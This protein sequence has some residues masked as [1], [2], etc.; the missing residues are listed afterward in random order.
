M[1]LECIGVF[2]GCCCKEVYRYPNNQSWYSINMDE[3]DSPL[4]Q[5]STNGGISC[6][7]RY[8]Y[9]QYQAF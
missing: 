9:M 1:W 4:T 5:Y 8:M 7:I 3:R 6:A 2:S